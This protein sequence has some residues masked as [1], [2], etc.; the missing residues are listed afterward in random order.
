MSRKASDA[1]RSQ[2][3]EV[4]VAASEARR[5]YE[6]MS[7]ES[8]EVKLRRV[9]RSVVIV[10]SRQGKRL[11]FW[12]KRADLLKV[13]EAAPQLAAMGAPIRIA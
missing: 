7:L 12:G 13:V 6:Y 8:I 5:R 3:L 1:L 10:L 11:K 4:L 9:F 2:P